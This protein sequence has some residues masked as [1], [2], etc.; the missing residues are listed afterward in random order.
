MEGEAGSLR[1]IQRGKIYVCK[2]TRNIEVCWV[3]KRARYIYKAM[4]F[5]NIDNLFGPRTSVHGMLQFVKI[6]L[7]PRTLKQGSLGDLFEHLCRL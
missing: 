6:Y 5:L 2:H 1:E 3:L 7:H 4:E